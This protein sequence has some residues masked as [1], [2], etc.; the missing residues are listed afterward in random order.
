MSD[1]RPDLPKD[2]RAA[3]SQLNR[4]CACLSVDHTALRAA[5]ESGSGLDYDQLCES[6]PHLF[7][8]TVVFAGEASLKR[9][10]EIVTAIESVVAMPV[11]Q[12]KVLGWAPAIAH[13]PVAARGVFLGYD[14]HLD[15][16]GP[17]LIEINTNAGGGLLNARL[18]RAQRA[19]CGPVAAMLPNGTAT[20]EDA[21]VAMFREEWR[22]AG[23]DK[24]LGCIAIVDETPG[25]QYLAPEFELFR[26]LFEA[27]GITALVAD[28]GELAWDGKRLTCRGQVVDL[29]YNRLT[30]FSLES[31]SSAA[32]RAAYEAD[33]VVVTPHP[34]AH[35][36]YA[37]KRN[38]MLLSDQA[39]LAALGVPEETRAV[40][41][42]GI[43][44]TVAVKAEDGER[45]WQERKRWFFKP[46]AG[47]GSRA[48]YR[49]DKLTKRVFEEILQGGYIAQEIVP[50]SERRVQVATQPQDMKLDLRCYVYAGN[51]QLVAARLYQGQTTNFRTP[52][53][54]FASV[55]AV[56]RHDRR[57]TA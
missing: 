32:I 53:G 5:L 52:G 4:E 25:E 17:R 42:A 48:A 51:V 3:A 28:P 37:D 10:A 35:A 50:P 45:F 40:L 49:G 12:D 31:G 36:L 27:N 46:A 41:L 7:S 2:C 20:V 13:R 43:P 54:G 30:D 18:A 8:D 29:V 38:L 39:Q 56:P 9:M 14:F 15:L 44:R 23:G 26:Q 1:F 11:Y 47:F 22:L 16:Q 21:F 57:G 24:P 6:R 55:L 33:G 34:R 19:C